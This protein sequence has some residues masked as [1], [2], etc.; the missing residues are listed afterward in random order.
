MRLGLRKDLHMQAYEAS[1]HFKSVLIDPRSISRSKMPF[2]DT[3]TDTQ[4][5]S[6]RAVDFPKTVLS[7]ETMKIDKSQQVQIEELTRRGASRRDVLRALAA[8]GVMSL[9]GAGLL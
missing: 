1:Q 8:G 7:G 4:T 2:I 3:Q 5:D 9:T 6:V